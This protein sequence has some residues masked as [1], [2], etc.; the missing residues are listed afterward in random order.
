ME[1]SIEEIEIEES[2]YTINP[3][4]RFHLYSMFIA[5]IDYQNR[6]SFPALVYAYPMPT[7]ASMHML[8]TKELLNGPIGVEVEPAD[9]ELLDTPIFNLNIAKLPPSTDA[10]ALPMLA[11]PSDITGTATQIT[12]FLKLTLDEISTLAPVPMDESTPIQPA[13]MDTETTS[14]TDQTLTDIPEEGMVDQSTS[15]DIVPI[16]PATMLP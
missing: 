15:M 7:M 1:T 4:S 16:E 10:S 3:H 5:I 12:D 14:I 11:A 9:E 8:T 6:F 2:D 13:A